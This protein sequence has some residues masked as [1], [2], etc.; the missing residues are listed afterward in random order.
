MLHWTD[1]VFRGWDAI[2]N[3]LSGGDC[4]KSLNKTYRFEL[5]L[6]GLIY[7]F[8]GLWRV[9]FQF[10]RFDLVS[11]RWQTVLKLAKFKILDWNIDNLAENVDNG[12][13]D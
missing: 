7:L 2:F 4:E 8:V 10:R 11:V 1:R 12:K 5:L 9:Y 13:Q 3:A 6:K